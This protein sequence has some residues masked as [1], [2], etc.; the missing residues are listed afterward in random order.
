MIK[1]IAI[2]VF[3]AV[4]GIVGVFLMGSKSSVHRKVGFI[5]ALIGDP[6]WLYLSL[7]SEQ[8]GMA[9]SVVVFTTLHIRGLIN[10]G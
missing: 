7:K 9:A 4:T 5:I 3:S 2:Q 6:V 1:T 8:Y 10:N